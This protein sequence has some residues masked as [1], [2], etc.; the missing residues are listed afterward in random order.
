MP[1]LESQIAKIHLFNPRSANNYVFVLTEKAGGSDAEIY[2]VAELPLLNPAA[3]KQCE[4][5]CLAVAGALKRAYKRP[6]TESSFEN[7]VAQ[8]N[9]ELGKLAEMGQNYWINKFNCIL[10]VKNQG[11]FTIATCG[12]ISAYLLRDNEL[13][14][15][16]TSETESHPLKTFESFATGKIRLGDILILSNTQLL[17]FVSVDRLK[18]ILKKENFLNA[19]QTVIELLKELAGPEVGFGTVF[20][21]QVPF[22][23]TGPEEI[24]LESY[25]VE[26]PAHVSFLKNLARFFKGLAGLDSSKRQN[27]TTLPRT[28]HSPGQNTTQPSSPL[29][30]INLGQAA[31][32]TSL[33]EKI[34]EI[35]NTGVKVWQTTKGVSKDF[36]GK[37]KTAGQ[38]ISPTQ[39]KQFSPTKKYFLI[40]VVFFI[41]AATLSITAAIYHKGKTQ[42]LEA[43]DSKLKAAVEKLQLAQSALLYKDEQQA[44]TYFSEA[45]STLPSNNEIPESKH[46]EANNLRRDFE[47]VKEQIEHKATAQVVSLGNLSQADRLISLPNYLAVQ[48]GSSLISYDKATGRI[49]DGKLKSESEILSSYGLKSPGNAIVYNGEALQVWK[50][51]AGTLGSPLI[52]SV[53]PKERFVGLSFYPT[54]SRI[55]LIDKQKNQVISFLVVNERLQ[56]PVVSV[57]E[58]TLGKAV[59]ITIDSNVYVLT[60]SGITK[61]TAGKLAPFEMPFLFEPFSGE[62][63]IYT[64]LGWENLYMLDKGNKRI[65]VLDKKGGLIKMLVSE[66]FSE[67]RDFAVD[68]PNRIIY[69]LNGTELLKVDY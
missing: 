29:A 52:S 41:V 68:E 8:V 51:E 55:Y 21:L 48:T 15:I 7:A 49:E 4:Q 57:T 60:T 61:F 31:P 26:T 46:E 54:N 14:D 30:S 9:E 40:A 44:R 17:N 25:I 39:I 2:M 38:A 3:L 56:N 32:K 59:D 12:K 10:G 27:K 18:N 37:L 33:G 43:A 45:L 1:Q 66:K 19:A 50:Y 5:I 67:I 35:K 69:V 6:L 64:E 58:A 34:A 63:R 42:K 16:S 24:D 62:G 65:L 53:P 28:V 13:A 36:S 47:A 11:E 22:G 20:N 23:Q